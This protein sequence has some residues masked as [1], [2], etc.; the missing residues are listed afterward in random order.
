V[1]V[2]FVLN[3]GSRTLYALYFGILDRKKSV[4]PIATL[5]FFLCICS[6]FTFLLRVYLWRERVCSRTMLS[7]KK[8]VCHA[9]LSFWAK[10]FPC[11]STD[12]SC[13]P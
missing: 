3:R 10:F 2:S 7:C 6:R 1:I 13:M 5:W 4:T 9:V 8:V 11:M 12:S